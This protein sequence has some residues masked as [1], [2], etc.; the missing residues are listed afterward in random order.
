MLDH[1]H[2]HVIGRV[3]AAKDMPGVVGNGGVSKHHFALGVAIELRNQQIVEVPER[4]LGPLAQVFT[5]AVGI[6]VV[7]LVP[8]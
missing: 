1:A 8:V 7:E 3:A 4:L 6:D 5:G 2:V